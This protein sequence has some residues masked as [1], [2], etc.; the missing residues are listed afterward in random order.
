VRVP[1]WKYPQVDIFVS[2]P[3]PHEVSLFPACFPAAEW[4]ASLRPQITFMTGNDIAFKEMGHLP[5]GITVS[6][7]IN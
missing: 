3:L 2:Q 7:P 5:V 4:A 6:F 1:W